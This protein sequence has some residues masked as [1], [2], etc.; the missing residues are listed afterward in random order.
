MRG[1]RASRAAQ[2][3]KSSHFGKPEQ[4][5]S[6][7]PGAFSG[8]SNGPDQVKNIP[9]WAKVPESTLRQQQGS[10]FKINGEANRRYAKGRGAVAPDPRPLA[11]VIPMVPRPK[12][13]VSKASATRTTSTAKAKAATAAPKKLASPKAKVAKAVKR[14]AARKPKIAAAKKTSKRAVA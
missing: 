10:Q 14:P 2:N 3:F 12:A 1:F 11:K 6:N 8:P 5:R 4:T 13:A 9:S 7:E